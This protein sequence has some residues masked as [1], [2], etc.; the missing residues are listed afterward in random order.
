MRRKIR[1][2]LAI[3][4]LIAE[5]EPSYLLW[6]L[7]QIITNSALSLLA[8]Y[9]P[10]RIL[11]TLT[12]VSTF[13]K[14]VQVILF[15]SMLLL[16]LNMINSYLSNRSNLAAAK[17]A[18][19]IRF[20]IGRITM[21]LEMKDIETASQR[22]IIQMANNAS[23]LT[24]ILGIVRQMISNVITI[25]GLAWIAV[26]LNV[27]F[28]LAIAVV[29][30]V[31]IL[32]SYL[33]FRFNIKARELYAKNDR[34]GDYLIG[35]AYFDNGA[36]KELRVN[37]L[38]GWFMKKIL[39]Y[40]E[41]MLQLQYKD[42]K[43]NALF[44]SIMAVLMGAQSLVVLVILADSYLDGTI[45]IA[46]F[47]MYFSAV[48]SLTAALN[49]LTQQI[50]CYNEQ[51]LNFTDYQKLVDLLTQTKIEATLDTEIPTQ[52]EIVF[53]DVTFA[54][55]GSDKNVLEHLNF[56]IQK[57]EK[58][59]IV[60]VNG[61]GK[62]TLIKLICK[63][64]RPTSGRILMNGKDIW[65]IPN[66]MY[67]RSIGAV[68]QDYR[69]FAFTLTENVSFS[70][71]TDSKRIHAIFREI[72]FGGFID[73]LPKGINT[74]LTRQFASD[75]IELSGGQDQKLAIARAIYKNA[76]LLILDEPTASL[77][78]KAESEIYADFG[79]MAKGKTV[80]FISHRMAAM[81]LA[82]Q[83]LVLNGG[84]IEEYG[85]HSKLIRNGGL[86]AKMYAAQSQEFIAT[87]SCS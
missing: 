81:M 73:N 31:K 47:T 34:V 36:Q 13:E 38:Q 46:D 11:E 29:L 83:I 65:S 10:K 57:G 84:R 52:A 39:L 74:S 42:F 24:G 9:V 55:P 85:S 30:A 33:Q 1:I 5:K 41:K 78:V 71:N 54:Y 8:V 23:G 16:F 76:P 19:E 51:M 80:V 49:A 18:S 48:T 79:R 20:E 72:G 60:G 7:P 59:M 66:E 58:L 50:R 53:D 28:L 82:E 68:F 64:Y 6:S 21:Q 87:E 56:T 67:Y 25:V 37:N 12:G 40:R 61:S 2:L 15:Y 3:L 75:G 27:L 43:R 44:E 63:L 69:N 77:D 17:F 86:Y 26:R 45:T 4:R 14:I 70:E 35:L 22:K 32:F 62:T